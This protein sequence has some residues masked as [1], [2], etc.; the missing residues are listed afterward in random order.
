MPS[1]VVQDV[2]DDEARLLVELC[3]CFADFL[4]LRCSK[5]AF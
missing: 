1:G 3:A 5:A 4:N 2:V